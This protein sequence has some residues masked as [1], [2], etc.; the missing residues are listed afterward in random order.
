MS[1]VWTDRGEQRIGDVGCLIGANYVSVANYGQV[2]EVRSRLREAN[3]AIGIGSQLE[4]ILDLSEL[5]RRRVVGGLQNIQLQLEYSS[6]RVR[7]AHIRSL[8]DL[9]R[10]KAF[11]ASVETAEALD[12][13][14]MDTAARRDLE[15]RG[16]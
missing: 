13:D 3:A 7:H 9:V 14:G 2:W 4:R 15:S 5:R 16:L 12:V 11:F 10:R 1:L 6:T 8:A